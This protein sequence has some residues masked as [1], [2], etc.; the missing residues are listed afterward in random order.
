VLLDTNRF[1]SVHYATIHR[2]LERVG[3]SLKKLKQIAKERNEQA[4]FDNPK[5]D[6]ILRSADGVNFHVFKLIL[7]LVSSH[8]ASCISSWGR[9]LVVSS[10][11]RR[12]LRLQGFDSG[13]CPMV[14]KQ[15]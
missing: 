12:P 15:D 1:V 11:L 13:L 10:C 4:P 14:V 6:I 8:H 5:C 7:S 3:V 2:E 9:D